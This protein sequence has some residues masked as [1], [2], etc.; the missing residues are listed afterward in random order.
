MQDIVTSSTS[1]S[2]TT[3]VIGPS[4]KMVVG[5]TVRALDSM[6][7]PVLL[8]VFVVCL[9]LL[10]WPLSQTSPLLPTFTPPTIDKERLSP[11]LE[12]TNTMYTQLQ[13][14]SLTS[15]STTGGQVP[16]STGKGGLVMSK[17]NGRAGRKS[18]LIRG[19]RSGLGV[20]EE[21]E[22]ELVAVEV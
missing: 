3:S 13:V 8:V 16:S 1:S 10:Q 5:V 7:L 22:G 14:Y 19:W 6:P 17:P 9:G 2:T 12:K 21:V 15:A 18:S 4:L 11:M 20:V